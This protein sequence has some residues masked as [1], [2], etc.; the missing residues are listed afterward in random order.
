ME[1]FERRDPKDH[2]RELTQLKET[3]SVE[4]CIFEFLRLSMMVPNLSEARRVIMFLEGLAEPLHGLVRS[5]RPTT[6]QDIVGRARDLQD[7]LPRAR[8][9]LPPR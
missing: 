9:P 1:H 5:N 6:L 3:G 8:A 2:F 7:A 4:A